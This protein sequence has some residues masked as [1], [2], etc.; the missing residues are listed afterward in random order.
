MSLILG[1]LALLMFL[2]FFIMSHVGDDRKAHRELVLVS[3]MFFIAAAIC[4]K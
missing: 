4:F 1:C 2:F 3:V